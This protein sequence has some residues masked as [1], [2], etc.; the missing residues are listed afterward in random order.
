LAKA[1]LAEASADARRIRE[2]WFHAYGHRTRK[3]EPTAL[4]IAARL[5]GIDPTELAAYEK[6]SARDAKRTAR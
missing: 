3:F 1:V 6:N 5:S 4:A 2:I